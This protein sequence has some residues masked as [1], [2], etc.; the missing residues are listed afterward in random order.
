MSKN[1]SG[2]QEKNKHSR[3]VMKTDLVQEDGVEV[4]TEVEEEEDNNPTTKQQWN[5]LYATSLDIFNLN[6]QDRIRK[7]TMLN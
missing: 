6:V 3:S 2:I 5:A 1:S 7:P 4:C